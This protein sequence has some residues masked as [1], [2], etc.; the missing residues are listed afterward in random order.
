MGLENPER[1]YTSKIGGGT[2]HIGSE[3]KGGMVVYWGV[4]GHCVAQFYCCCDKIANRNKLQG[5]FI[6]LMVSGGGRGN[7]THTMITK[8]YERK[9]T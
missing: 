5:R 7:A 1:S 8:K 9:G 4:G 6:W 3:K 2:S